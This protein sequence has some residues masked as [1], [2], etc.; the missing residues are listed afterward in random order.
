MFDIR[1]LLFSYI[2]RLSLSLT[3]IKTLPRG[4]RIHLHLSLFS[5]PLSSPAPPRSL[6]NTDLT[7]SIH[8]YKPTS[9]VEAGHHNYPSIISRV[10]SFLSVLVCLVS[11]V[12]HGT[13]VRVDLLSTTLA[14]PSLISFSL[15]L[16]PLH[17]GRPFQ[18]RS[19]YFIQY[20]ATTHVHSTSPNRIVYPHEPTNI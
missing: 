20:T 8:E 14:A 17:L 2:S 9:L 5:L 12:S 13:R 19:L 4:S 15:Y 7:G 10:L 11:T 18:S 1:P 16:L 3:D 6:Y